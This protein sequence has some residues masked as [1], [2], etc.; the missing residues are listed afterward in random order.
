MVATR[1]ARAPFGIRHLSSHLAALLVRIFNN[2]NKHKQKG[3]AHTHARWQIF[4]LP[5][6]QST[7]LPAVAVALVYSLLSPAWSSKK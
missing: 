3:C 1:S 4:N 2:A 7:L 5:L 6:L